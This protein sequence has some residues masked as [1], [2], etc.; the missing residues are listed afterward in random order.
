MNEKPPRPAQWCQ[1][2]K[3]KNH[4][5]HASAMVSGKRGGVIS[6]CGNRG[7]CRRPCR[8]ACRRPCRRPC[9]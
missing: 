4:R 1:E 7:S 9:F 5:A 3:M 2:I 6:A 8:R